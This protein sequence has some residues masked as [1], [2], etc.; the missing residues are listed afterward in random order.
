[1]AGHGRRPRTRAV[2]RPAGGGRAGRG[3]WAAARRS[4]GKRPRWRR[5]RPRPRRCAPH[6]PPIPPSNPHLI[7]RVLGRVR[8]HE[9]GGRGAEKGVEAQVV[10]ADG[11]GEGAVVGFEVGPLDGD[12]G[13]LGLD[14]G[15]QDGGIM[16]RGRGRR[17]AGAARAARAGHGRIRRRGGAAASGVVEDKPL[18]EGQKLG[19]HRR[20]NC[21]V[22]GRR[23]GHRVRHRDDRR[24]RCRSAMGG[25]RGRGDAGGGGVA[26]L[27]PLA[28]PRAHTRRDRRAG[29][30]APASAPT[31]RRP[32]ARRRPSASDAAWRG[33]SGDWSSPNPSAP[34]SSDGRPRAPRGRRR[35]WRAR[36]AAGGVGG[37]AP[38]GRGRRQLGRRRRQGRAGRPAGRVRAG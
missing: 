17:A 5:P 20:A 24:G 35:L 32:I 4:G 16:G 29:P 19:A 18:E 3:A 10:V 7:D 31:N 12:G 15:G 38:C 27:P 11:V 36:P 25:R 2:C 9:I 26:R 33:A 30:P 8:A 6:P 28:R 37:D 22:V 14:H 23:G 1:M 34:P 21:G 13:F